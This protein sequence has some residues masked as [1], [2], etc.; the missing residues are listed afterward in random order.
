[1]VATSVSKNNA[2]QPDVFENAVVASNSSVIRR[3]SNVI[4]STS[5]AA[6]SL[7]CCYNVD[8]STSRQRHIRSDGNTWFIRYVVATITRIRRCSN[9][10]YHTSLTTSSLRRYYNV[11]CSAWWQCH[12]GRAA[13]TW[14][15]HC[16]ESEVVTTLE[17]RR[18]CQRRQLIHDVTIPS[19]NNVISKLQ[20]VVA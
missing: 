12:I 6:S 17:I 16:I 19:C 7:Q 2:R 4:Y 14:F 9:V 11:T 10:R 3:F 1:M 18:C 20:N 15:I 8:C 13:K 5:L